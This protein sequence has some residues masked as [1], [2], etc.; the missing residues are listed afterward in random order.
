MPAMTA[1]GFDAVL[2]VKVVH[3]VQLRAEPTQWH[4]NV[5]EVREVSL[6]SLRVLSAFVAGHVF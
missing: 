5:Y 1:P 4:Y 3:G 6:D 2:S